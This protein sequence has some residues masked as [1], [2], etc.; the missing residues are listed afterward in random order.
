MSEDDH[1]GVDVTHLLGKRRDQRTKEYESAQHCL[2]T[3]VDFLA[4]SGKEDEP[5]RA[6]GDIAQRVL[7][8]SAALATARRFISVC[9]GG[10]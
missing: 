5:P 7:T 2:R 4:V 8:R 3:L 1:E 10:E 6:I 9:E